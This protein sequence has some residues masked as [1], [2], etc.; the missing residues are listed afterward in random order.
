MVRDIAKSNVK[1][2]LRKDTC[3]YFNPKYTDEI[4]E[5]GKIV[6]SKLKK[7]SSDNDK[8]YLTDKAK[9]MIKN[10]SNHI[11]RDVFYNA[12]VAI[13]EVRKLK[14]KYEII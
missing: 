12:D 4:L 10:Y 11:F 7:L 14:K 6:L 1:D 13:E 5:G 8:Y 2:F 3:V 9:N